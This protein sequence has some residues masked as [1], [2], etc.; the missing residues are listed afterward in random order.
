MTRST[1]RDLYDFYN[2]FK[3]NLFT[4]EE[5]SLI[6][7]C[8]IFYRAISNED[9]NYDFDISN[10][11]HISQNDIKRLLYP[12]ISST[13]RFSLTEAVSTVADQFLIHFVPNEKEQLFLDEFKKRKYHP[14]LLFDDIEIVNQLKNHPMAIWKM[15]EKTHDIER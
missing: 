10:I 13:E 1:P 6:R 5:L 2:L 3:Y 14:E 8:A 12:V 9:D 11:K 7:K 4:E 15:K